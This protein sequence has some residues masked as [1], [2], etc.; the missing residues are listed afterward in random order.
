MREM[1]MKRH[2]L[3]SWSA[4]DIV[5]FLL[6]TVV[7][8]G[9]SF[10]MMLMHPTLQS[11]EGFPGL[12]VWLLAVWSPS[13]AAGLVATR[14]GKLTFLLR[15]SLS[16]PLNV[17]AL[18]LGIMPLIGLVAMLP[19]KEASWPEFL[20]I[21]QL[22]FLFFIH[23]IMGPLGE[24]LG[25]RGFLYPALRSRI[26]WMGAALGVGAIWALWHGPLWLID[27]PQSEIPFPLFLGNVVIF[28]VLMAI[29]VERTGPSL[30]GPVLLHLSINVSGALYSLLGMG[31]PQTYWTYSLMFLGALALFGAAVQNSGTG[32]GCVP[33]GSAEQAPGEY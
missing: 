27:S 4:K 17:P 29:L 13:I 18:I 2:E 15:K 12:L 24:E 9:I 11:P 22:A 23:L 8:A 10:S 3:Y 30:L 6:C 19:I 5:A 20:G 25:W 26:G 16:S 33:P 28:S 21:G 31:T 14:R 32:V 1:E 7:I